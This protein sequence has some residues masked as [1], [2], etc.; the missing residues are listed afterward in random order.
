LLYW[1]EGDWESAGKQIATTHYLNY[2][3][4]P[5]GTLYLLRNHTK[6]REERIFTYEN[7]KQMWW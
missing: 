1:Q 4:V 3:H 7:G 6:G 2:N 5:A